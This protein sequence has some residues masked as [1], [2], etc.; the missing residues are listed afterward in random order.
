MTTMSTAIL[1]AGLAMLKSTAAYPLQVQYPVDGLETQP[2]HKVWVLIKA[3]KKSKCSNEFPYTVTTEGV[4]DVIELTPQKKEELCAPPPKWK[5][6][7]LCTKNART[8]LTLTPA[9]GK[10]AFA[11]AVITSVQDNTLYTETIEAIQMDDK[12]SLTMRMQQEMTVA[13]DLIKH[14]ATGVATPWSD[15][16]SPLGAAACRKLSY[17]PTGP[18]LDPIQP[19]ATKIPRLV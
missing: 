6:V 13:V 1:P 16:T 11:L 7:S 12:T 14:A 10:P 18:E 17:S 15:T 5:L 8:S 9:H 4:E 3:T 19:S 2:C